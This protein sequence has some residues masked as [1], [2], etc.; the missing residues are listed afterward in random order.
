MGCPAMPLCW[1]TERDTHKENRLKLHCD[2]MSCD[3]TWRHEYGWLEMNSCVIHWLKWECDEQNN[4]VM[5][6]WWLKLWPKYDSMVWYLAE[7][8]D[9]KWRIENVDSCSFSFSVTYDLN[10]FFFVSFL[11][12][13][14]AIVNIYFLWLAFTK[15]TLIF[16]RDFLFR[17]NV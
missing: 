7:T 8:L 3:L 15:M 14:F 2:A 16:E 9:K 17:N 1:E 11:N 4:H 13:F 6:D 10:W 12:M 5:F